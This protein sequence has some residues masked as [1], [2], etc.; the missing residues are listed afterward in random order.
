MPTYKQYQVKDPAFDAFNPDLLAQSALGTSRGKQIQEQAAMQSANYKSATSGWRLTND[1]AELNVSTALASLDIPDTTTA[2]SFHVDSSGNAWWGTNIA[3]GYATAPAKVLATGAATFTSATIGNWTVNSTSIYTGTEDHT[4]YTTNAGDITLYSDGTD[5]SIHAKNFYIDTGGVLNA[6]SAIISGTLSATAGAIGGWTINGTSIYTGTEDHS[7]YTTN[8]GDMT[9]YSDGA[10]SSIHANK[11]YIDSTGKFF[12]TSGAVSGVSVTAVPNDASTDISLLTFTHDLVFSATDNNTVAWT[13][14]TITMSNGRT[15]SIAPGNNTGN[16][17]ALTWIYL[18][19]SS[20]D[21]PTALSTTATATT[22]LGAKKIVLAIAQN[23]ADASA[24]ATF[25]VHGGTTGIAITAGSVKTATLSAIAADLGSITA[26]TVTGATL[27]TSSS[28]P[29]F[30][31]TSTAF[32][33]I[34]T[35]G[36]VVFEVVVDGANAGDVIMGDDASGSYAMWDDSA[37]TFN[38]FADN[39]P[40]SENIAQFCGDGSTGS[41]TISSNTTL[42]ADKYYTNLTVNNSVRLITDGYKVYVKGTL[43]MGGASAI[44]SNNG[45]T[46][47]TGGNGGNGAAGGDAGTAGTGGTAVGGGTTATNTLTGTAGGAGAAGDTGG[48][49]NAPAGTAGTNDTNTLVTNNGAA[50]AIGGAGGANGGN[51]G[52]DGGAVGSVGTSTIATRTVHT[53]AE[54]QLFVNFSTATAPALYHVSGTAGGS[55]GG[56]AGGGSGGTEGGG[57][58]GSGGAGSNGGVC[59]VFARTISGTGIIE[60]NGGTGGTGGNGGLGSTSGGGGGGAG[61]TGGN[62]GAVLCAYISKAVGVTLRAN[63]GTGGTGGTKGSG[64]GGGSDGVDGTVGNSGNA[65]TVIEF[66]LST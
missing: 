10:N 32:Q 24:N 46:G 43:T 4:T 38:V 57:G 9:I 65:G 31:M 58:G 55:G 40:I 1:S 66:D 42:T 54:A 16:M 30:N 26:G 62:G 20:S 48:G 39:V 2:N 28:N 51:P 50:G 61:G 5:S 8:E 35:G 64:A 63:G 11:F 6:Q 33:G 15:F 44:I 12:S 19:A 14:G 45:S 37:G 18:D 60:A 23:N 52:G 29:K 47:G 27:R 59:F 17:V 41:A 13:T 25:V 53:I 22:A 49:D 7:G 56:G 34:E 3:T 36:T 21:T